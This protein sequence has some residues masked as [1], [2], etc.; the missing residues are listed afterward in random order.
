MYWCH[1]LVSCTGVMYLCHVLVSCTG[2]MYWCHVL[3]ARV[4]AQV[5]GGAL[6]SVR[7][8]LIYMASFTLLL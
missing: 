6:I 1:V 4:V 3:V 7:G 8:S 5:S 2:V